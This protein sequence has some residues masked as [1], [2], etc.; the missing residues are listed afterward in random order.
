MK[1]TDVETM[2]VEYPDDGTERTYVVAFDP[3]SS[4][5]DIRGTI[6]AIVGDD[7]TVLLTAGNGIVVRSP[8]DLT[9]YRERPAVL[10]VGEVSVSPIEPI[11]KRRPRRE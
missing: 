4:P 9:A 11:R 5:D 8:R 7:G 2:D 3:A 6:T 10:H 1:T